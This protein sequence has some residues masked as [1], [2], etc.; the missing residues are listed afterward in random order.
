MFR[1]SSAL[2]A[3]AVLMS[4]ILA[5]PQATGQERNDRL[6]TAIRL[7]RTLNP[8]ES[9]RDR[10][11]TMYASMTP[12][13]AQAAQQGALPPDFGDRIT[14]VMDE[15]MPYDTFIRIFADEYAQRFSVEEL[16]DILRFYNSPTGTKMLNVS[17]DI[18][19]EFMKRMTT[20]IMPRMQ[21][22][23]RRQGLIK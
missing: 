23:M 16:V 21:D 5:M 1:H 3:I 15:V 7:A 12:M 2:V 9:Y 18:G 8:E 11:R 19:V 4:S 13:F 22:A 17:T 10:L 20:E 14:R 6:Q